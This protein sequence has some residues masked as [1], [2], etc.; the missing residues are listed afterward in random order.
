MKAEHLEIDRL[1]RE[2]KKLK[3]ER[4]ILKT[5]PSRRSPVAYRNRG[6]YLRQS[7][8]SGRQLIGGAVPVKKRGPWV[9]ADL[10]MVTSLATIPIRKMMTGMTQTLQLCKEKENRPCAK[11]APRCIWRPSIL[12]VQTT[13]FEASVPSHGIS[14]SS[15]IGFNPAE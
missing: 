8:G 15:R 7:E 12:P 14:I 11:L 10:R 2:V 13:P 9:F 1:R 6:A 4:D 5:I 3:A